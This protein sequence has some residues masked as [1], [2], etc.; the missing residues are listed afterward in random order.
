MKKYEVLFYI[1]LGLI[2]W[3]IAI[4][5]NYPPS[6]EQLFLVNNLW[7]LWLLRLVCFLTIVFILGWWR[8]FLRKTK[9]GLLAFSFVVV[10]GMSP[11]LWL[12]WVAY[13]SLVLWLLLLT[14]GV[15]VFFDKNKF[16]LVTFLLLWIVGLLVINSKFLDQD[17]A[18]LNDL[19][20]KNSSE[21][22]TMIFTRSD[23]LK[24]VIEVP[25][26]I[27]RISYNKVYLGFVDVLKNA[28]SF[29]DF[30]TWFFQ[31]VHPLRQKSVVFFFWPELVFF[32]VGL[33]CLSKVR[34][35]LYILFLL[36]VLALL[37]YL[38]SAGFVY[39]RMYLVLIPVGLLV[40]MGLEKVL[41]SLCSKNWISKYLSIFL[42]FLLFLGYINNVYDL[43][44]RPDYWLDNRPIIYDQIYSEIKKEYL[45]E[46]I[47][48]SNIFG[49]PEPYCEFY[50]NNCD[51]MSYGVTD[52]R[53]VGAGIL[54]VGYI[55][56]FI[57][58]NSN[59]NEEALI[60][61]NGL[62]YLGGFDVRDNIVN[63]YGQRVV[64]VKKNE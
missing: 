42:L 8:S 12:S 60:N 49:N 52:Y 48:V 26:I 34:K 3:I 50:L 47:I 63:G 32:F 1:G 58:I 17:I 62:R 19:S 13:P 64:F 28:I 7:Q 25:L 16:F 38:F 61:Q 53:E 37:Y 5:I 9:G 39:Q 54:M 18:L 41:L 35:F 23:S 21:K 10:L 45:G 44:I 30:D 14:L 51:E 6:K 15:S 22:V 29:F 56:E 24:E 55:G 2:A 43:L 59:G 57:D 31:E 33:V 20:F 27:K 36:I 4:N 11:L 46:K 40:A